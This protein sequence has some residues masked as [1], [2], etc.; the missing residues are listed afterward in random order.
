MI[1]FTLSVIV[2]IICAVINKKGKTTN[3]ISPDTTQP[4]DTL[5]NVKAGQQGAVV[6]FKLHKRFDLFKRITIFSGL[7]KEPLW[8][9]SLPEKVD[10]YVNPRY[11]FAD[12]TESEDL[13]TD[14]GP[15]IGYRISP[16]LVIHSMVGTSYFHSEINDFIENFG[17][18]L[19][20]KE[21]LDVLRKN[22]NKV[23]EL[24][25]FAGDTK[26]PNGYFWAKPLGS[27]IE[28]VHPLLPDNY[29][30]TAKVAN[31]IAKR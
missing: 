4:L 19:L 6:P 28:A 13:K 23:S 30:E 5:R 16:S 3:Y 8:Q 17:G 24:R 7:G 12:L 25:E 1:F 18:K 22:F 27:I 9:G 15:I 31:I 26:L 2:L 10:D 20:E 14:H 21:D 11:V 29:N